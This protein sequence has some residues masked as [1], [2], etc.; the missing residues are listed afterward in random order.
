M[1]VSKTLQ[2]AL[3]L[4]GTL[5]IPAAKAMEEQHLE[6]LSIACKERGFEIIDGAKRPY[7]KIEKQICD[8]T[9]ER[10]DLLQKRKNRI[11]ASFNVVCD[12][13]TYGT[14]ARDVL[15]KACLFV[16]QEILSDIIGK[17]ASDNS[18]VANW[19]ALQ[20][21]LTSF[22]NEFFVPISTMNDLEGK[23]EHEEKIQSL[24]AQ[25]AIAGAEIDTFHGEGEKPMLRTHFFSLAVDLE[26]LNRKLPCANPEVIKERI[27]NDTDSVLRNAY[28]SDKDR[29]LAIKVRDHLETNFN[30]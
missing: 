30:K 15:I 20:P 16:P 24:H 13:Y 1:N 14:T 11:N 17:I 28:A 21:R 2:L 27:Q 26:L 4:C 23:K 10:K 18:Q 22:V 8:E 7:R 9:Q 3:L 25:A 19:V 12:A 5:N 29:E 6:S